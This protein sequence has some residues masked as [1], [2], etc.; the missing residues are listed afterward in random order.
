MTNLCSG[1]KSRG[2]NQTVKEIRFS[3]FS[4]VKVKFKSAVLPHSY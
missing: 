3:L 4:R 2:S 1:V